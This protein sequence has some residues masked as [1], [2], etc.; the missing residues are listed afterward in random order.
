VQGRV[1]HDSVAIS[2]NQV[3]YCLAGL[4]RLQEAV[5]WFERAAAAAQKGDVRGNV[6]SERVATILGL[7]SQCLDHLKRAGQAAPGA[8]KAPDT[9]QK[10][11]S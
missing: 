7:R 4:G 2:Q 11:S 8:G 1:D 3:G 6:N 10:R 9:D 5:S